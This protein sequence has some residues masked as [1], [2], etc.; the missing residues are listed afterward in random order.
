MTET[1]SGLRATVQ[2]SN[3]MNALKHTATLTRKLRRDAAKNVRLDV[4]TTGAM[5]ITSANHNMVLQVACP[6]DNA[7]Q[8][9]ISLPIAETSQI[10]SF[11]R[12]ETI[13]LSQDE[14]TLKA[15]SGD[16]E[17]TIQEASWVDYFGTTDAEFE[18]FVAIGRSD[19]IELTNSVAPSV[20]RNDAKPQYTGIRLWGGDWVS[21]TAT[22]GV[23]VAG[24]T[25]NE[26]TAKVRREAQAIIPVEA[27]RLATAL[28]RPGEEIDVS[29]SAKLVRVMGHSFTVWT[30]LLDGEY[31]DPWPLLPDNYPTTVTIDRGVFL[32][33]LKAIAALKN[34]DLR[35][36][37]T[38]E[39]DRLIV[40]ASSRG[41]TSSLIRRLPAT[42]SGGSM[43]VDLNAHRLAQLLAGFKGAEVRLELSGRCNPVRIVCDDQPNLRYALLPL[44][45]H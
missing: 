23:Q 8:G 33:T 15:V 28:A 25:G 35:A 14:F 20:S 4:L 40:Q 18:P 30:R 17:A 41:M 42:V 19:L 7:Q 39:P 6:V 3:I 2:T 27:I 26:K 43:N 24:W 37:L 32:Q 34:A 1:T 10:M 45:T 21:A 38:L 9:S 22:D 16:D 12:G 31:R 36:K 11:F 5:F 44:I 13:N 29:L